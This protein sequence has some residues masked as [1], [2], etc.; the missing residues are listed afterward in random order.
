MRI[1]FD[2]KRAFFNKSGLGNYSRWFIDALCQFYPENEYY[3][4]KLK[5]I[6]GVDFQGLK[7]SKIITPQSFINKKIPNYWRT[8]SITK[9]IANLELDIFHGLSHELPIGIS[10]TSAKSI[11]TMHDAIF[12]RFPHLYDVGYRIIFRKKYRH[13]LNVADG[14]I[15]ISQQSKDDIVEYFGTDPNRIKVIY[16]GCNP[17]YY[18]PTTAEEIAKIKS[19]YNL[20]DEFI[21]YVGTIEPRKNLLGV[22][23]ALVNSKI[24][25]P[26]VAVGRPT[27]YLEEVKSFVTSNNLNNK[28]VFLHYVETPELPALYQMA[29]LFVYPS[30]FEGFGIP[31]LEALN[32]GIPVVTSKGSCF[33]EVGGEAAQYAEYG[34]V[35]ELGEIIKIILNDLDLQ[36]KMI[37]RGK[38]QAMKFRE[39]ELTRE[40]VAFYSELLSH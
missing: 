3:L 16:Q 10:K 24:D 11:V 27:Q 19:K 22:F 14:I 1:G 17:I 8:S 4:F 25:M 38:R 34:N 21:L 13:A 7:N 32:S 36:Q 28:A 9:D 33:P 2:A 37:Q 30:L 26:V 6:G 40:L 5:N 20:P 23:K 12:M 31:I 39:E 29:K 35:E 18:H 15:A